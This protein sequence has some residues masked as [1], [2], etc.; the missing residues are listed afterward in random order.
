MR[1]K[2]GEEISFDEIQSFFYEER[3]HPFWKCVGVT[4]SSHFDPWHCPGSLQ[5]FPFLA[6]Y[7]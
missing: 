3:V 6:T 4:Y 2:H 5:T 7:L 1:K